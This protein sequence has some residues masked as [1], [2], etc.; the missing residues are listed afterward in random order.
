MA[1]NKYVSLVSG[2]LTEISAT[3]SSAGAGDAGK[4]LAL[5]SA[6]KV[7][8]SAMPVGVAQE[9][10]VLATSE[11]LSSGN[12][13][14]IYD[15]GGTATA[16]K[17]DASNGRKA[18]GFVLAST[19]SPANAN[20]FLE[21]TITGLTSLTIGANM[22]LSTVGAASATAPS[23]SGHISQE[24]GVAISATEITFEPQ[25]TVTLA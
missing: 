11:N 16:R 2:Q 4:I 19:T 5:D 8:I 1:G 13:V 23:T 21:G 10:K 22:Y 17:A 3:Q 14:N 20:V 24:I 18:H 25:R 15:N 7:D 6:G 12:L 9:V